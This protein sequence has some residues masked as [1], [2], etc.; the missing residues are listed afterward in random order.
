MWHFLFHIIRGVEEVRNPKPF[1]RPLIIGAI[2]GLI[3][4]IVHN[5][6]VKTL[7]KDEYDSMAN[8]FGVILVYGFIIY[9]GY[10]FYK[11]YSQAK[12]QKTE[13]KKESETIRALENM[14]DPSVVLHHK[15]PPKNENGP[16]VEKYEQ[17]DNPVLQGKERY[18]LLK[19]M[20][21][22]LIFFIIAFYFIFS[23]FSPSPKKQSP[24][25]PDQEID[26][27]SD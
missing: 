20:V 8:L 1:L 23:V 11:G 21:T 16:R 6:L 22:Y 2:A 17:Q 25:L 12:K 19:K 24:N 10:A 4:S 15:T 14:V 26:I 7:S 3:L 13:T 27:G 5:I 18:A 9:L